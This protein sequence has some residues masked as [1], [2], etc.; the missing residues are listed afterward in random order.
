MGRTKGGKGMKMPKTGT[1]VYIKKSSRYTNYETTG[2][3]IEKPFTVVAIIKKHTGIKKAKLNNGLVISSGELTDI[4]CS[5]MICGKC[6]YHCK[7]R[8]T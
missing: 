3:D 1:T 5:V 6:K 7:G 4:P 2:I 8:E